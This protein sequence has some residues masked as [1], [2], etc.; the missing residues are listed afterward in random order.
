MKINKLS[1]RD[2]SI[3][4]LSI[5]SKIVS[6]LV[7]AYLSGNDFEV[8]KIVRKNSPLLSKEAFASELNDQ[9]KMLE[10]AEAAVEALVRLW[11]NEKNPSCL[12]VLR[13]IRDTGLFKV[14]SRVDELLTEFSEGE[15]EKVTVLRKA[16]SVPFYELERYSSFKIYRSVSWRMQVQVNQVKHRFQREYGTDIDEF[17]D[18]IYQAGMD[19]NEDDAN[20]RYRVEAISS[21]NRFLK[22]IDE[23][24][25]LMRQYHPQGEKYYWILYYTYMSAR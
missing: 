17:L 15:N 5:L 16:L 20:I 11:D 10:E 2:G 1:L 9:T 18:S 25:E 14:G 6:P 3:T 7:T 12:E 13:L 4:E 23:A 19:L 24:V 8:A 21:S 22:L